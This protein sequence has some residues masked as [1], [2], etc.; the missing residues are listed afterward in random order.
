MDKGFE[1]ENILIQRFDN[2]S[3]E[4]IKKFKLLKNELL[5]SQYILNAAISSN[6]PHAIGNDMEVNWEGGKGDQKI[7]TTWAYVDKEFFEPMA[8]NL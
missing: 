1:E 3:N 2:L 6:L 8:L 7:W 4:R 5:E